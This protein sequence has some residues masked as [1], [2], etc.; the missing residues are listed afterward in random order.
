MICTAELDP[1]RDE[2]EAYAKRLAAA[3]VP[4]T[5]FREPGMI[6]GYFGMGGASPAAEAARRR[7]SSKFK[8]LLIGVA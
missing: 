7:A 4:V 3:G 5:Y 1:L 8:E 6:H 2:G